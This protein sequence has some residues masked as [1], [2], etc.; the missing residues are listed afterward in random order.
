[1]HNEELFF[2]MIKHQRKHIPENYRL[3]WKDMKR[4]L[5]YIDSSIFNKDC[6]IWK[7]YITY[8]KNVYVNFYLHGRKIALNRV[9]YI[10]FID[11]L[12]E[13]NYLTFKCNKKG[14]ISLNCICIK[15]SKKYSKNIVTPKK[16]TK[17]N[18][19]TVTFF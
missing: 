7:G 13:N 12:F 14:C 15:N 16:S 3:Y 9:L 1:M 2:E 17:K 4:I 11:D 19:I 18:S 6:T 8:N 5:K 10:N